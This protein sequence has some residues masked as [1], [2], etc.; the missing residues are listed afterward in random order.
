MNEK[1]GYKI[2]LKV[3]Y[4]F[5]KRTFLKCPNQKYWCTFGS[6]KCPL[7]GCEHNGVI[8]V[9]QKGCCYQQ[10]NFKISKKLIV[11]MCIVIKKRI[12]LNKNDYIKKHI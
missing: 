10:K 11:E 9:L 6:K 7:D 8:L 1:G 3:E 12:F 4:H 5:L 2:F